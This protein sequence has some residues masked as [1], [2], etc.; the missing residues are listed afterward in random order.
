MHFL[1]YSLTIAALISTASLHAATVDGFDGSFYYDA[2][3]PP[4]PV[5]H[6]SSVSPSALKALDDAEAA[7]RSQFAEA[8]ADP[9]A[10]LLMRCTLQLQNTGD[11]PGAYK[12]TMASVKKQ[13]EASLAGLIGDLR[14]ARQALRTQRGDPK[15]EY[16]LTNEAAAYK[17]LEDTLKWS[18]SIHRE[19]F[20]TDTVQG[21]FNKLQGRLKKTTLALEDGLPVFAFA[22]A[23]PPLSPEDPMALY[24]QLTETWAQKITA[25]PR[26][27]ETAS[28]QPH[29]TIVQRLALLIAGIEELK[30]Q[31]AEHENP[32][33]TP[34]SPTDP[35]NTMRP[36]L[37]DASPTQTATQ[38]AED[39]LSILEVE[40]LSGQELSPQNISSLLAIM[41]RTT[42]LDIFKGLVEDADRLAEERNMLYPPPEQ[43]V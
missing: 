18:T 30:D 26:G 21:T 27:D 17:H 11:A 13:I 42:L 37:E 3:P 4:S 8:E 19:S 7:F 36:L 20:L 1:R 10:A 33:D 5:K 38:Q 9:Y 35:E 22:E 25:A 14:D 39:L 29:A 23:T 43:W 16:P 34:A 40:A 12:A 15:R 31:I 32:D 6:G 41:Y 28:T 24:R 2:S